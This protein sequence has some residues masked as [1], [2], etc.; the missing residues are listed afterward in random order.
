VTAS[1]Q[2]G[3]AEQLREE[4]ERT[5]ELLGETVEQLAAKVDVKG[6]ARAKATELA[7]QVTRQAKSTVAQGR[8][9]AAQARKQ[10]AE[11]ARTNRVPVSAAAGGVLL[12]AIAFVIWRRS[13]G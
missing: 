9:R 10:G 12:A 4:I 6:R 3:D 5:R 2:T 7:G 11:T 8:V 1:E 13:K